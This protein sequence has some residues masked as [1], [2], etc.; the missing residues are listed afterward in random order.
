MV[1]VSRGACLC[2]RLVLVFQPRNRELA[3]R[4]LQYFGGEIDVLVSDRNIFPCA[5]CGEPVNALLTEV[6]EDDEHFLSKW[7]QDLEQELED[8]DMNASDFD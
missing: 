1:I 6:L 5:A 3:Q 2:G 7:M 8:L 4:V